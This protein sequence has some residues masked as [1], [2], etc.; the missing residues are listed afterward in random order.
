MYVAGE[1]KVRTGEMSEDELTL[2]VMQRLQ[3]K[4]DRL[5]QERDEAVTKLEVT[6]PPK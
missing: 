5:R 2:M 3:S 1:E 6:E 4:V